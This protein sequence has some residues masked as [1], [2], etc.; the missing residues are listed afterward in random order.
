MQRDTHASSNKQR[1]CAFRLG[2]EI[3]NF[4]AH[5]K[6]PTLLRTRVHARECE[7]GGEGEGKRERGREGE[8]ES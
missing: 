2:I 6:M 4:A 3:E 7:E 8:H 5:A 1:S